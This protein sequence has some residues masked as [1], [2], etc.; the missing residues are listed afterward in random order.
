MFRNVSPAPSYTLPL[1]TL[2]TGRGRRRRGGY[3]GRR[4]RRRRSFRTSPTFWSS[5]RGCRFCN[6]MDYYVSSDYSS[7]LSEDYD[8]EDEDM[9]IEYVRKYKKPKHSY[10]RGHAEDFAANSYGEES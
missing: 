1:I 2:S 7:D 9:D 10:I 3:R 8:D 5:R 6:L 4:R